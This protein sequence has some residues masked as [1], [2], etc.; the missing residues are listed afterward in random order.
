MDRQITL[1]L[2]TFFAI[3][4]VTLKLTDYF[5]FKYFIT[6][7]LILLKQTDRLLFIQILLQYLKYVKNGQTNYFVFK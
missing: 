5:L 4:N 3:S 7:T 6:I 1:Y 2:N